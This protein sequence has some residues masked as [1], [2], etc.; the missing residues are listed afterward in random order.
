MHSMIGLA[1]V[2]IAIAA[3]A[4]PGPSASSHKGEPI[5]GGNRLRAL[6]RRVRRRDHLQ[7]LGDRLRQA[8]GQVQVPAVQ[9]R[10]GGSFSGQHMLNL[11]LG[12]AMLGSA[13]GS[14]SPRAGRRSGDARDRLRARRADHHPDR[15]RRH[16]GRGLDAQQLLGLGRRRHR[17]LAEQLDA[18]HRRF[19]GR[20]LGRDP[21]LHHVQGD[22]PLVLQRPPR[23]LRRRGARLRR[24][25]RRSSGRSRAAAPTT[26][27]SCSAMPRRW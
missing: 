9:G 24:R 21:A 19:A 13:C 15:R 18:D 10:A 2:F 1:A 23:R 16:A 27:R 22:E 8:L 14:R 6:H 20:L 26:P 17:L 25:Q 3:V 12:I 4:E 5:P 7:R 11:V